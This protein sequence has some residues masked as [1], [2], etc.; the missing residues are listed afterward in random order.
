M[1]RHI[2][3]RATDLRIEVLNLVEEN[4]IMKENISKLQARLI[5]GGE[6]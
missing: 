1:V 6:E 5:E 3:Q 2:F 4:Q